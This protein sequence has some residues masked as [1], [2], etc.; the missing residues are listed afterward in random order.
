MDFTFSLEQCA[1]PDT[2]RKFCETEIAPLAREA[3]DKEC[4]PREMFK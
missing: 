1:L 3:D 4:F 2:V